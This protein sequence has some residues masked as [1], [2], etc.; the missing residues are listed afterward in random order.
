MPAT[1][2]TYISTHSKFDGKEETAVFIVPRHSV[3]RF[4]ELYP[5]AQL[6]DDL[7]KFEKKL[8]FD[9]DAYELHY[10]DLKFEVGPQTTYY[11]AKKYIQIKD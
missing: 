10:K 9:V 3:K 6:S 4:E 11:G 5:Q 1:T 7:Y 8:R 2:Y